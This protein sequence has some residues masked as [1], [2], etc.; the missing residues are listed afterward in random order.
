[1]A[2]FTNPEYLRVWPV[3]TQLGCPQ[4]LQ[5]WDLNHWC[6]SSRET[7]KHGPEQPPQENQDLPNTE[8]ALLSGFAS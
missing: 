7:L 5:G 2:E 8:V 6:Q 4:P 1:M 3:C